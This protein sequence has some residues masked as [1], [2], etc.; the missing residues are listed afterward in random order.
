MLLY[1]LPRKFQ[2][3]IPGK[4]ESGMQAVRALKPIRVG[5]IAICL[6]TLSGADIEVAAPFLFIA[7]AARNDGQQNGLAVQLLI[8]CGCSHCI[9]LHLF[10]IERID[11]NILKPER[12]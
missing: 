10:L 2:R 8:G 5:R 7:R 3:N 11:F 9:L 4:L 6:L 1:V 12:G